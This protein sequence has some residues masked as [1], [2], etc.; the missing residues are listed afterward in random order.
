MLTVLPL[1]LCLDDFAYA[2]LKL[3]MLGL[4]LICYMLPQPWSCESP[5]LGNPHR[6]NLWKI[7]SQSEVTSQ[8]GV[9]STM[10]IMMTI[11]IMHAIKILCSASK[12]IQ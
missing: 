9:V 5:F 12:M 11:C 4:D 7:V 2:I 1:K 3:F 6:R 8:S 10:M